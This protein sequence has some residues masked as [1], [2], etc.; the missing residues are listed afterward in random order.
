M[1]TVSFKFK[2]ND[3]SFTMCFSL[4]KKSMESNESPSTNSFIKIVR[5]MLHI[6]SVRCLKFY[7]RLTKNQIT[8]LQEFSCQSTKT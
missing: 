6:I 4:V 2:V 7:T 3:K 5:T 1:N 8:L